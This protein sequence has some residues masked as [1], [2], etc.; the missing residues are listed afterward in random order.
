EWAVVFVNGQLGG[1]GYGNTGMLPVRPTDIHV[2]CFWLSGVQLR[3]P[4]RL[5]FC[6]PGKPALHLLAISNP[7]DNK[8]A[9]PE[10]GPALLYSV[11]FLFAE[12]LEARI[13]PK[14]IKHWIELKQRRSERRI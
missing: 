3:W 5:Q 1:A 9:L 7:T 10:S 13:I 12:F 14:R 2:R 6:V 8:R 4:H 11:R